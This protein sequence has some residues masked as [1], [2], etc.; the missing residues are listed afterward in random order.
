MLT[1][2]YPILATFALSLVSLIGIF[3]IPF[4]KFKQTIPL[5]VAFAAGSM[6]GDVFLHLLPH[7]VDENIKNNNPTNFIWIIVGI[8][9][10]YLLET[11]LHWHHD[12]EVHDSHTSHSIG[13]IAVV[14]D[15]L[16]NFFDGLGIAASFAINP[17]VG[18]ATTIAFIAHEIPHELGTFAVFVS[19]GWSRS[20]ALLIN[21]CS[22]LASVA[23]ALTGMLLIKNLETI[24]QPILMITAGSLIYIALADLIPESNKSN[25]HHHKTFRFATFASFIIGVVVMYGLIYLESIIGLK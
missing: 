7:S 9:L 17:T 2:Y 1:Y 12:H 11:A 13:I 16:H 19:S 8:I 4:A 10:F 18:I 14:G 23:G 22:G 6:I 15:V 5:L 21:F 3:T 25:M 24:E 20:K